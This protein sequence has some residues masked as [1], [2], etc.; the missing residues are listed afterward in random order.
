MELLG[1]LEL[2]LDDAP[3]LL[4]TGVHDGRVPESVNGDPFLPNAVR[5][6]LGLLDNDRRYARDCYALQ[7]MLHAREHI[8]ILTNHYNSEGSPQTPSR[9][10]LAVQPN[11]LAN[12]IMTILKPITG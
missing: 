1:W 8:R 4:L 6:R 3:V 2:T 12:R 5:T 10:L 11:D 9:L 7:V